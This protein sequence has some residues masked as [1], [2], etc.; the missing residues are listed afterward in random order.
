MK[1]NSPC[2]GCTER[3]LA[4][5]DRCPK[6]ERGEYGHKAWLGRHHAQQ[7]HL[8]DNRYRFNVPLS[9]AREKSKRAYLRFGG[10]HQKGGIQ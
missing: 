1:E 9:V 7:K 4:C 10:G 3:F 6:D 8:K 5:S 2:Y